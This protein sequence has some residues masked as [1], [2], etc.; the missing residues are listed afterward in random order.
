M[1][2]PLATLWRALGTVGRVLG[3][4]VILGAVALAVVV[5]FPGAIGAEA[6]Y[7]VLSDSMSPHIRAGDLVVVRSIDAEDIE[8][9][10]VI[11]FRRE[12]DGGPD[13]V[14]HRVVAV[15]RT[16]GG[17]RYVTK[18]DASEAR[19]QQRVPP[20]AVEGKVWFHVPLVGRLIVFAGTDTGLLLLVV[21]PS[22]ALIAS[23]LYSLYRD[24]VIRERDRKDEDSR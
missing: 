7:V 13:R 3:T 14:T 11:T 15:E 2:G 12:T 23:E 21:L 20:E 1:S 16:D 17:P 19:D 8:V 10:E 18:G 22:V 9:G 5:V 4:F 24:A 6:S